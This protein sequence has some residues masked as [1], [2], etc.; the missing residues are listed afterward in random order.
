MGLF[1]A[2]GIGMRGLNAA[3]TSIDVTGQNIS[4]ANTEGYSRK[5]VD[6][7][8][9]VVNNEVFGQIGQG[10][11]VTS[12][13]RVRDE[14]L[15]RQIWESNGDVGETTEL[16]TA[17]TRLENILKE[18]TENGLAAQMNKFW[19][20]F[21]DLANNP[22]NA[23]AREAVKA[24]ANVMTDA[25]HSVY[26]QIEDYGLSMNNPLIEKAKSVNDLTGQ[27]YL[28]NE[29]VAGV[30][31]HPGEKANDT[32]DQRDLLVRKLAGLV[33]VQTVED[34]NGRVM[35]TSGG[36]LLVGASEALKITTYGVD[37]QLSDGT[38]TTELRLRFE[39]SKKNYEPRGGSL[40][41][42]MDARSTVLTGYKEKLNALAKALV[43]GVND[44]HT[45]GYTRNQA[46]GVYFF[47]PNKLK[48]GD[49]TL[50]DA[51][52]ADSA[53]IAA[54]AGG[55]IQDVTTLAVPGGVPAAGSPTLDLKTAFANPNYQN[56]TQGGVKVTLG[57][58]AVLEEGPG[59]DYL[60]DYEKGTITFINYARYAAGAPVNVKFAYNTTGYPGDGNGENAANIAKVRLASTMAGG[61]NGFTQSIS[62]YYAGVIGKLGIEK[63][64][65]SSR[66]DTKTF[67]I[68]QMQTEQASV[69]GV[70]LDEEMTNMIKYENSYKA[71][72]KYI[73]TI[74]AMMEVL[75]G[76][77]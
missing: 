52:S 62:D 20:S 42:I 32:R 44:A 65:N 7:S 41:G 8:A 57:S 70:S 29:K 68:D 48:A 6:Q 13:S 49:L 36:N 33:D 31:A 61:A 14:F 2:L 9:G 28:L 38:K 11:D 15:D 27:I 67:L 58:G 16:D 55:K 74:S 22:A 35:I 10:V 34:K 50:S 69:S 54:A 76:I 21:Q 25:F 5:V 30:E 46:T 4:N 43:T 39:D 45:A 3:Q 19:S 1:D 77:Q 40:K 26:K 18:P 73:Q 64:Q 24:S 71:S 63:N 56:L 59:K 51:V 66:K 60:V 23:S 72:A 53:N 37:T 75:M 47:D 12:I 17:Y